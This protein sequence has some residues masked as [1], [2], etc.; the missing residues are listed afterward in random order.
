[1]NHFPYINNI[2]Y[3]NHM[4]NINNVN[5]MNN[6]NNINN[7]NRINNMNNM[8]NMNFCNN[9]FCQQ[10]TMINTQKPITNVSK[11]N[12]INDTSFINSTLQAFLSIICINTWL[13]GLENKQNF[14]MSGNLQITKEL[15]NLFSSLFKGFFP[16]SSNFILNYFNKVKFLTNLKI[17]TPIDFLIYLIQMVHYE[18]NSPQNPNQNMNILNNL[19]FEQ[20]INDNYVRNLFL[21]L[22]NQTQNS[23]ISNSFYNII[24]QEISCIKC[25]TR[26]MYEYKYMIKFDI[27]EYIKYRNDFSPEKT[28]FALNL[29][30]C[31]D[32]YTGGYKFKCHRCG[33]NDA[34]IYKTIYKFAN[35]LLIALKRKHHSFF[36]DLDFSNNLN[37]MGYSNNQL[38]MNNNTNFI[39]K[40][41]VSLNK[42]GKSV[43]YICINNVWFCYYDKQCSKLIN[44]NAELKAFEPQLLIYES[45]QNN[46]NFNNNNCNMNYNFNNIAHQMQV[47]ANQNMMGMGMNFN[48]I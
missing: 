1:M 29:E 9:N 5:N 4:N 18:T 42:E 43:S 26:Y 48:L 45:V 34:K 38:E 47:G 22:L 12:D 40:A 17:E 30:N 13:K 44:I 14:F 8:N 15:F 10:N 21:T 39:L 31:F 23:I 36:C 2:N 37:L 46:C 20:Q 32:C 6:M 27:N 41:V 24:R 11:I 7:M 19:T 25:S 16:D 3:I 33:N 28:N 35:V